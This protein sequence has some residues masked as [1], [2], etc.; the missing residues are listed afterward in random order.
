MDRKWYP[1]ILIAILGTALIFV[2]TCSRGKAKP[3]VTNNRRDPSS[4]VDRNR[5]FDRRISYIEYT[6]HAKCR[7]E[8]RHISQAEVEEIMQDGKV[9]YYKS[10][11]NAHP[12]PAY[13]LEG[14]TKDNQRVRIVFGQCDEKTKVI[15]V[16]D[17]DRDWSCSCPGDDEK[18]RNRN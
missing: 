2:R 12:C 18:Y 10:D 6:E 16:I 9:N 15:T 7:M 3:T 1:F 13:A 11:L 8:C 4:Q 17:L 5:G 14:V